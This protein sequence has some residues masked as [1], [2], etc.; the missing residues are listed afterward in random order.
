MQIFKP[1]LVVCAA[2]LAIMPFSL[3]AADTEAQIRA[4]EALE[5]KLS[6][7]PPQ[8]P[9]PP[10]IA[11]GKPK[12]TPAQPAAKKQ[13]P[14]PVQPA[15]DQP[16]PPPVVEATPPPPPAPAPAAQATPAPAAPETA[17][18]P[19][20]QRQWPRPDSDQAAK[21]REALRQK[22]EELNAQQAA[23]P[24]VTTPREPTPAPP[25]PPPAVTAEPPPAV[26]AQPPPPPPTTTEPAPPPPNHASSKGDRVAAKK[27]YREPKAQPQPK[28]VVGRTA[29]PTFNRMDGPALPIS[30]DK[31]Q[32]LAT[33]LQ[34]Y[35]AD[36]LT[37]AQYHEARAKILAEP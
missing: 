6:E 37:P 31:Q 2:A 12:K 20:A 1:S 14:P 5:K 17:A 32:R 30:A 34:Q 27:A 10:A 35:Q 4:R 29:Q 8:E 25:P 24:P 13:A 7:M 9:A 26:V 22:I 23:A 33:L 3:Q 19:P 28:P 18:Q 21:A 36:Q 15:S 11:P 16:A